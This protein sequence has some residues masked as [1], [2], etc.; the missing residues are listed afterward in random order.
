ME[1]LKPTSFMFSSAISVDENDIHVA[2]YLCDIVKLRFCFVW[3]VI[4]HGCGCFLGLLIKH[5]G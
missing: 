4:Q 2:S 5:L 3:Q 1:I